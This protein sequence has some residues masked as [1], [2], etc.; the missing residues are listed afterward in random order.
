MRKLLI[1]G[2]LI[3]ASSAFA[4][5]NTVS[6]KAWIEGMQDK[7]PAALCQEKQYFRQCF[8]ITEKE[9]LSVAENATR[10]CLKSRQNEIPPVLVQPN[11]GRRW[12]RLVGECAGDA[13]ETALK[14]KRI[15]SDKCNDVN[16]W[17]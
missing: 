12:G 1:V 17:I 6:R 9:C 16:N 5:E 10:M 14:N 11:D 2:I 8:R 3:V 13:F 4:Q 7:L 15:N